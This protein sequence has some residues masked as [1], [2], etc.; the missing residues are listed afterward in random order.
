MN[1]INIMN[2]FIFIFALIISFFTAISANDIIL[3]LLAIE[4]QSLSS[5]ILT[6]YKF[7][8]IK[9]T[10]AAIKYF[11]F[12][13]FS[14]IIFILG[15]V[16][17]YCLTG[18]FNI[19]NLYNLLLTEL[20]PDIKYY[21]SI[22]FIIMFFNLFFKLAIVPF[23]FW[24]VDVYESAPIISVIIF[25]VLNKIANIVILL[26]I[27]FEI[28]NIFI[29]PFVISLLA[30]LS[31][32]LGSIGAIIQNNIRKFIAYS[33][34]TNVGFIL[35]CLDINN[36]LSIY[37][38]IYFMYIYLLLIIILFIIVLNLRNF[39]NYKYQLNIYNYKYLI[40]NNILNIILFLT[41]LSFAGIPPFSGFFS[42]FNIIISILQFNM[43]LSSIIL[44]ILSIIIAI[45]YLR[46]IRF[47][48]FNSQ[49]KTKKIEKPILEKKNCYII[50]IFSIFN[51]FF[52]FFSGYYSVL[53]FNSIKFFFEG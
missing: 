31:I 33:A 6:S 7:Y 35:I 48:F 25:A 27:S 19:K 21:T 53:I 52:L 4:L 9:A 5:F 17:I 43:F 46:I 1:N 22:I 12:G 28:M 34:I 3:L 41:M 11:I 8:K 38:V 13:S 39:A 14:S 32:F 51:I 45:Y 16:L 29:N 37:S 18:T 47:L 20:T 2:I 15:I 26:K 42:K 24:I 30:F 49:A 40:D 44:T 10:E 36:Y 50:T 23:H